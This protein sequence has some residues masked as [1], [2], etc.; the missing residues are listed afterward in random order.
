[1]PIPLS[2]KST[3]PA[4]TDWRAI[5]LLALGFGLVGVD[6]FMISTMFPV[7]AEDLDLD[8]S[9][10]GV[11][12]GA[13]S[14]AWG[15]A[16][17]FMGNKADRLGRRL[18]IVG[19]LIAF[20]LMIGVHGLA[21]GLLGLVVVRVLM[22]LADGAYVPSSIAAT[23][24]SAAP[25]HHGRATGLQQMTSALFGL[26]LAP[27]V[28]AWL[29]NIV[30]WRWV[31]LFMSVPGFILAYLLWRWL[32]R[33]IEEA[34]VTTN[35]LADWR[36]V[37]AIRNVRLAMG[38]MLC[39]LTSLITLSAFMPSYLLEVEKFSF[40]QMS[41]VMS[42][43]G[44]GSG[45]GTLILPAV[46]DYLG[47]KP[48]VFFSAICGATG[49]LLFMAAPSNPF[50]MFALLFIVNFCT[51][52]SIALTVGP[53]T[54]EAV[55]AALMA[56]ASGVVICAG[57]LLGGGLFPIV[58]GHLIT[59]FGIENFLIMPIISLSVAAVISIFLIETRTKSA[60]VATS[61]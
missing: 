9:D 38:L 10:I 20:S 25:R 33:Q 28:V 54:A 56:T 23:L 24:E 37:L 3:G 6:R 61:A 55:P 18:V 60:G 59:Y 45:I 2:G 5:T 12:T 29:L 4:R 13:L 51:S 30:D 17:L 44:I 39:W 21:T 57:E 27:L 47:R 53:I 16:A 1:M 43:I 22:G 11:I 19:S 26:G 15:L 58:A 42:A 34:P 32:P 46:S 50:I 14:I 40:T 8:Y 7:I 52:A 31:F 41:L 48:V 35:S 36:C 49:L